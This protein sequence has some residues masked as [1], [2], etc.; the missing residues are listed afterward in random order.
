MG[1]G[2]GVWGS[3]AGFGGGGCSGLGLLGA[4][5][6]GSSEAGAWGWG[7]WAGGCSAGYGAGGCSGSGLL[8][9]GPGWGRAWGGGRWPGAAPGWGPIPA[10]S[11]RSRVRCRPRVGAARTPA[12]GG[13][14]YGW[15][16]APG[17]PALGQGGLGGR[18]R[19]GGRRRLGV[20]G[21]GLGPAGV[22]CRCPVGRAEGP[23]RGGGWWDSG[24]GWRLVG[25]GAGVGCS[26]VR[27]RV[28]VGWG[29][30]LMPKAVLGWAGACGS[31]RSSAH[32][33]RSTVSPEGRAPLGRSTG[34][35]HL[36]VGAP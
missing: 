23:I 17:G 18:L 1:G 5:A 11:G 28:G 9:G 20:A 14:R 27:R 19:V 36:A 31:L 2:G 33:G 6:G 35:R 25:F 30:G 7:L 8:G 16:Q 22:V 10:G 12:P 4:G 32:G 13:A 26:V 34:G 15:G 29:W 24:P 3:R 21:T